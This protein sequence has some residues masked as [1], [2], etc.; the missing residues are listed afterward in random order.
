MG[1]I[2]KDEIAG[3]V[4]SQNWQQPTASTLEAGRGEDPRAMA[5]VLPSTPTA[6][7]GPLKNGSGSFRIIC[8]I[9]VIKGMASPA[10]RTA[11][12]DDRAG[13]P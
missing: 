4:P 5:Q 2:L 12:L 11:N 13:S 10:A 8:R 7:A 1:K 3:F 6:F 9:M